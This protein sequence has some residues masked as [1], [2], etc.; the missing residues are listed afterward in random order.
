[1]LTQALQAALL[2]PSY[3]VASTLLKDRGISLDVK[4]L[5]RLCQLA[6]DLNIH[7]RGRMS[8]TGQ[9]CLRGRTLVIGID[10]GR[11]R[12]RRRKRGAKAEKLKRQG[13][14]T[15][16]KEPKL[17]TIYLTDEKGDIVKEF[18]PLHRVRFKLSPSF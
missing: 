2:S 6:G 7:S 12:E 5:R 9:E 11:L 3:D 1:M 14:R 15:E 8:L 4:A 13:Y 10:G 18:K 16:W 17:S